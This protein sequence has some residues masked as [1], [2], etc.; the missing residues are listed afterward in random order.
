MKILFVS[1]VFPWPLHSGGQIRIYNLL[2]R[3]SRKHEITLLSFIRKKEEEQFVS[4]LPF[5]TKVA[6]VYRGKAWKFNYIVSSLFGIFPFLLTTY[7]NRQMKDTIAAELSQEPYDVIHI[8]P[9]YVWPSLPKTHTPI[10]VG[11]HNIEYEVYQTYVA[12]FPLA[13]L[14][15]F[16]YLDTVKMRFWEEYIWRNADAVT[17]VSKNDT[18]RIKNF[19]KNV[20]DVPN[21]VDLREFR[22]MEYRQAHPAPVLLFVGNFNWLPNRDAVKILVTS[23][24]PK[25]Q[26][27]YPDA[28]LRIVGKNIPS[29][30]LMHAQDQAVSVE[31]SVTDIGLV[32]RQA[33]VLVAPISIAGGT[34][35]KMLEAFASG[36]PVVT[37]KEGVA[38]LGVTPGSEYFEADKPLDF[39]DQIKNIWE[40]K[41][42]RQNITKNARK[43][44]EEN[45]DWEP[46]SKKLDE[47]WTHTYEKRH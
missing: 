30:I 5:C 28:R 34:K 44:V 13:P 9:F 45:F 42:M 27:V 32:Y 6:T 7:N 14:R 3:L 29:W 40:H 26:E 8:E 21:G 19:S 24:W 10:V 37:S 11:E 23:I 47:V 25:V 15:P 16:L 22:F 43:F 1:A 20:W 39:V 18:R 38:G 4:K 31:E 17:A 46:I 36:L 41:A 35:F 12:R 2:K 33:D